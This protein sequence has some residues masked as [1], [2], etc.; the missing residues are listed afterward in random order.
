MTITTNKRTNNKK[1]IVS[2][3]IIDL[4]G[5]A[6]LS[7]HEAKLSKF[8]AEIFPYKISW[9]LESNN[10]EDAVKEA[11]ERALNWIN[12]IQKILTNTNPTDLILENPRKFTVIISTP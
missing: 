8:E 10:I 7:V 12:S 3:A 1:E 4:G 5:A 9:S 11:H 2:R 6:F